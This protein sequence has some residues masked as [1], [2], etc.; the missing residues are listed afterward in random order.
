MTSESTSSAHALAAGS[1]M[2]ECLSFRLGSVEYGID[3]LQVQEIRSYAEPTHI[4]NAPDE[5]LGVINLRGVIVPIIDL[6]IKLRCQTVAYNASTVVIVLNLRNKVIG[7]VADS[8]SD[9]VQLEPGSITPPAAIRSDADTRFI[10]GMA[11]VGD[12][13][14][15]L[16][17]T[18]SF[19]GGPHPGLPA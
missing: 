16:M 6:R 10:S 18:E 17:D 1:S 13:M 14:L 15:I 19:L 7:V 8:V 12:R 2:N 3:L 9:V 11:R 5:V 4:A